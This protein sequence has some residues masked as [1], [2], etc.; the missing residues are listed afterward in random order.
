VDRSVGRG[1]SST[2]WRPATPGPITARSAAALDFIHSGARP[3]E[4]GRSK[5]VAIP[6]AVPR[7]RCCA[8]WNTP[9]SSS[10]PIQ[11]HM[12]EE[13]RR[14]VGDRRRPV[15]RHLR[16]EDFKGQRHRAANSATPMR[17]GPVGGSRPSAREVGRSG[18]TY[19]LHFRAVRYQLSAEVRGLWSCRGQSQFRGC[20]AFPFKRVG[21]RASA[22]T[23]G[24][25]SSVVFPRG[26]V[27][28]PGQDHN[29]PL[30]RKAIAESGP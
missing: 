10:E 27:E 9:R 16:R 20:R 11:E 23:G 19:E 2:G 8:R 30:P 7:S 1:L 13:R 25:P 17:A 14:P 5:I 4:P 3:E 18:V 12:I 21:V 29:P 28:G 24:G 22:R 15:G 6:R 26:E